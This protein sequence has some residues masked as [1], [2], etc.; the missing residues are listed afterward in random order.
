MEKRRPSDL[1]PE[2]IAAEA[3]KSEASRRAADEEDSGFFNLQGALLEAEAK[4]ATGPKDAVIDI[5]PR[6]LRILCEQDDESENNKP[7]QEEE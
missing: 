6:V 3:R 2:Q 5:D 4:M 1:T 7:P